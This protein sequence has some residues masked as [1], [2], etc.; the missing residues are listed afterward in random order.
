MKLEHDL[1]HWWANWKHYLLRFLALLLLISVSPK[2]AIFMSHKSKTLNMSY[3]F[4]PPMLVI[5]GMLGHGL[6]NI[7]GIGWVKLG[8]F[9]MTWPLAWKIGFTGKRADEVRHEVAWLI[10]YEG[11]SPLSLVH[12]KAKRKTEQS[13]GQ[14][15]RGKIASEL[16]VSLS[17]Q[18]YR[19]LSPSWT[20][21]FGIILYAPFQHIYLCL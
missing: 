17:L 2:L 10:R 18:I 20:A 1:D 4:H 13:Q 7:W 3:V 21:V 19:S 6:L 12:L 14:S 11:F 8:A 15:Q 16:S 5:R 9:P